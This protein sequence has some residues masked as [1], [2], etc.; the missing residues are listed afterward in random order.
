MIF[1]KCLLFL[2]L[3]MLVVTFIPIFLSFSRNRGMQQLICFCLFC[4][5]GMFSPQME[6][7]SELPILKLSPRTVYLMFLVQAFS[8]SMPLYFSSRRNNVPLVVSFPLTKP[9]QLLGKQILAQ[10]FSADLAF[11]NS[12]IDNSTYK[13]HTEFKAQGRTRYYLGHGHGN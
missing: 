5:F 7:P 9:H 3:H 6:V 8:Q 13:M 12:I 10:T 11:V 2:C 1:P 4:C